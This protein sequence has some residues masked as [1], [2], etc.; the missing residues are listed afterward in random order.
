MEVFDQCAVY[1]NGSLDANCVDVSIGI[2]DSDQVVTLL[3]QGSTKTVALA[4]GGRYLTIQWSSAV[5]QVGHGLRLWQKFID[6]DEVTIRVVQQ[7]GGSSI[8]SRGQ[9]QAPSLRAQVG[10]NQIQSN[11]FIGEVAGWV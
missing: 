11:T 1:V 2:D 9:L 5:P 8:T 7:G 6:C 3:G 10:T 4:P